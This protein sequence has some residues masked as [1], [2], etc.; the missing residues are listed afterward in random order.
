M[1]WRNE[2]VERQIT[3]TTL[4]PLN[5]EVEETS[6]CSE[7]W[8]FLMFLFTPSMAVVAFRAEGTL[9]IGS[10]IHKSLELLAC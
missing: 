9:R 5:T 7:A 4:P 10:T 3:T 8:N 2:W 6:D 1:L